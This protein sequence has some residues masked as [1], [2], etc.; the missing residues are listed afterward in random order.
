MSKK[1]EFEPNDAGI[2]ELLSSAGVAA[3]LRRVAEKRYA[4][5]P[6]GYG[7]RETRTPQRAAISISTETAA[8]REDNSKNNTL[9]KVLG[10]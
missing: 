6:K 10:R 8:A 1:V 9:L 4:R 2:R 7:L 5:L 3:E